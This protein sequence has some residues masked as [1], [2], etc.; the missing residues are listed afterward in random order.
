[1]NSSKNTAHLLLVSES[2]LWALFPIITIFSLNHISPLLSAG[3]SSLIAGGLFA[4]VMTSKGFWKE[5]FI[6][7]AWADMLAATIIIGIL[8]YALN[9]IALQYTSAGN[10]SILTLTEIGFSFLV[11][12]VI[13]RRESITKNKVLGGF[14]MSMG[15]VAILFENAT[16]LNIGDLMV[17]LAAALANFGNFFAKRAMQLVSSITLMFVRSVIA[18]VA[19]VLMALMMEDSFAGISNSWVFLLINGV[20]LLGISKIMWLEAIKLV[21]VSHAVNFAP[22]STAFTLL[23]A[24]FFLQE[25][26][27]WVQIFGFV[28]IAL[29]VYILTK[30]TKGSANLSS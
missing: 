16:A 24:Y 9:F 18:G 21:D 10:K 4:A 30:T 12:G 25:I 15:A 29:G 3:I 20:L 13:F 5:L 26:P 2:T 19:L 27:S 17:I 22:L 14:L 23:F 1:M 6:K 8:F 11:F 28:P 7:E